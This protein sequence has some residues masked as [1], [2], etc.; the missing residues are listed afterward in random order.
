M[1]RRP[2]SWM[3]NAFATVVLFFSGSSQTEEGEGRELRRW[4]V[5]GVFPNSVVPFLGTW[6]NGPGR[7]QRLEQGRDLAATERERTSVAKFGELSPTFWSSSMMLMWETLRWW[8]L[9]LGYMRSSNNNDGHGGKELGDSALWWMG[10]NKKG[11]ASF[12]VMRST[13]WRGWHGRK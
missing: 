11:R 8:R 10:H 1:P 3:N 9:G 5:H 4:C 12:S 2:L 7:L 6:S 13:S